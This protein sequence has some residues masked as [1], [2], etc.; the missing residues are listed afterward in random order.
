MRSILYE[1]AVKNDLFDEGYNYS[2]MLNMSV[3]VFATASLKFSYE[4]LN[5]L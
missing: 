5:G 3:L 1:T 2:D 4:F